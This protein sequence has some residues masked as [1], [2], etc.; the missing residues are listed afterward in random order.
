MGPWAKR[1][2]LRVARRFEPLYLP[3]PLL[4]GLARVLGTLV[5]T[6]ALP[7]FHTWQRLSLHGAITR[8]LDRDDHPWHAGQLLEQLAEILLGSFLVPPML[9]ENSEPVAVLIH[10]PPEIMTFAMNGEDDLIEV[11]IVPRFG[12]AAELIGIRLPKLS[13]PRA[14]GFVCQ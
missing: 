6:P 3:L 12:T 11:P 1:K 8:Q 14:H 9:L 5:Q 2:R 13:T 4:R 10:S 7:M